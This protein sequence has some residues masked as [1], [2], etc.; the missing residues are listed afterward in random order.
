[1]PGAC[2]VMRV[3]DTLYPYVMPREDSSVFNRPLALFT[4][5][6]ARWS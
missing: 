2:S 3:D 1:M 6:S 5:R 4:A